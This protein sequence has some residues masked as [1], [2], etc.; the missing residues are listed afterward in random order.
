M[1]RVIKKITTGIVSSLL[2][3]YPALVLAAASKGFEN[4][5]GDN[6]TI[7][8][9]LTSVIQWLLGIAGFLAM[10]AIVW[11][12]ITYVISLGDENRVQRAKQILFWAITGLVVIVLSFSIIVFVADIIA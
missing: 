11:G 6:V 3:F 9:F 1:K 2:F 8:S 10:L 4:P 5:L 12:G 7:G